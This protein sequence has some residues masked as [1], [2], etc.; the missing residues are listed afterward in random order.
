M[1]QGPAVSEPEVPP[2][3]I[4]AVRDAGA[5]IDRH[6]DHWVARAVAEMGRQPGLDPVILSAAIGQLIAEEYGSTEPKPVNMLSHAVVRLA[7]LTPPGQA[8]PGA[9][10]DE[11]A[12]G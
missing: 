8:G 3:L 7:Q 4:A 11:F 9:P 6:L 1:G 12:T 5:Q 2:A 10:P